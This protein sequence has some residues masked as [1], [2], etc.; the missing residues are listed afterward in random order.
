MA[1]SLFESK[2]RS[3]SMMTDSATKRYQKLLKEKPAV[4]QSTPLKYIASYLGI[5]D[6][7]LSQ[8]RKETAKL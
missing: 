1:Q 2:Q 4:L 5:T 8:I 3:I 7:S 6:S